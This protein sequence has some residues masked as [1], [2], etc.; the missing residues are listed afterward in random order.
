MIIGGGLGVRFGERFTEQIER[1]MGKHLFADDRPPNG[2]GRRAGR[3][4]RRDR[5]LA[6]VQAL[7]PVR[8]EPELAN[9]ESVAAEF[10]EQRR[11]IGRRP[12]ES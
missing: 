2:A 3:P 11:A 5:R 8:F 6:A 12:G 7:S 10:A 9:R 1:E 4:R